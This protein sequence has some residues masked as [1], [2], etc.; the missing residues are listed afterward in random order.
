VGEIGPG[1]LTLLGIRQGDT[2]READWLIKKIVGLRIFEDDA[3][4]MNRSLIDTGGQHLIVSQFT[5]WADASKG[6]RP[7]FIEA[8]RPETALPLYEKAVTLSRELGV[9]TSQGRFQASMVVS[10]ENDGPVTILL[11]SPNPRTSP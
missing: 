1:L 3:G 6:N 4:K 7:S 5:L 8:A 10:L 2:E 11:D 9:P